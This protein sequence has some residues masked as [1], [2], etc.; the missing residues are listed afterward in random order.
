MTGSLMGSLFICIFLLHIWLASAACPNDCSKRGRCDNENQC[1]C[2]ELY[3]RAADC[4][5][6]VCPYGVS[7][8]DK[9]YEINKAHGWQECSGN[10]LCTLD[11]GVCSCFEGFEGNACE[12]VT[13]NCL[14]GS[15]E[16]I[17]SLYESSVP[18][19][20]NVSYALWDGN[21]TTAC[22]CDYG[23]TGPHCDMSE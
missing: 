7:F 21:I 9:A 16:T 8:S 6:K 20:S 17:S 2:E 14:Y 5:Q 23:Y 10:G 1:V 12:K 22:V 13:C 19:Y 18:V 15:C 11:S 4:S 3:T